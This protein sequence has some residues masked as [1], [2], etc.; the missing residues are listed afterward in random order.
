MKGIPFN[1]LFFFIFSTAL[2]LI[3]FFTL[4]RGFN[5]ILKEEL[6]TFLHLDDDRLMLNTL[7]T[8]VIY[9]DQNVTVITSNGHVIEAEYAICT[10]S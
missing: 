1:F 8:E 10:F 7:V 5:H 2:S 9:N 4:Y 3:I 6:R